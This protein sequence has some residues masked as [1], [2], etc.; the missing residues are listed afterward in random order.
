MITIKGVQH[1]VT[2]AVD[3]YS[4]QQGNG[5][6]LARCVCGWRDS[7]PFRH[8]PETQQRKPAEDYARF[9]LQGAACDHIR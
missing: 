4:F 8:D 1:E 7:R 5:E 9:K 6:L 2:I 3:F